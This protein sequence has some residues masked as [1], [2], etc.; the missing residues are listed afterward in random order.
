MTGSGELNFYGPNKAWSLGLGDSQIATT[1]A[2][3]SD[4]ELDLIQDGFSD[5]NF[6]FAWGGSSIHVG[7]R[8]WNDNVL[9]QT[10]NNPMYINGA[11][12]VGTNNLSIFGARQ[13]ALNADL[14]GTGNLRILSVDYIGDDAVAGAGGGV[15]FDDTELGHIADGWNNIAFDQSNILIID[16]DGYEFKDPTV[17]TT[18]NAGSLSVNDTMTV[19][20]GSNASFNFRGYSN[21]LAIANNIDINAEIDTSAAAPGAGQVTFGNAT[22]LNLGADIT[23]GG[24]D[25]TIADSV[26]TTT[27]DLATSNAEINLNADSGVISIGTGGVSA[28]DN[29][30]LRLNAEDFNINGDLTMRTLRF[31]ANNNVDFGLGDSEA[32]ATAHLSDAELDHIISTSYRTYFSANTLDVGA[33]S[34]N[35]NTQ[36]SGTINI[37]GTQTVNGG[38]SLTMVLGS[39]NSSINADLTGTGDLIFRVTGFG[40]LFEIGDG[41]VSAELNNA[42]LDRIVDGWNSIIFNSGNDGITFDTGGTYTFTD[43]VSFNARGGPGGGDIVI[44]SELQ[45]AAGSDAGYRFSSGG[46]AASHTADINA[47]IDLSAGDGTGDIVF[48]DLDAVSIGADITTAGGDI[49][50]ADDVTTTTLTT[51][52]ILDS[53]SGTISL[54]VGGLNAGANDVTFIA[55]DLM[56]NGA[57]T[58]TQNLRILPG[59]VSRSIGLGGGAGDLNINDAELALIN[60]GGQLIIGSANAGDI[61]LD[62]WDLSSTNYDVEIYGDEIDL[63]GITMGDGSFLAYAQ[64]TNSFE[65]L[66]VSDVISRTSAG[67][68]TLDLRANRNISL[69]TG[70][71]VISSTGSLNV[72]LNSDRDALLGGAVLVDG[73]SITTNDGY[74]VMGGGSGNIG[75]VDG[76]LGNG[77]GTGADDIFAGHSGSPGRGGIDISNISN[78][79]TGTGDIFVRGKSGNNLRD[80]ISIDSTAKSIT[81]TSGNISIIGQSSFTGRAV[82]ILNNNSI[83]TIDGD[84]DIHGEITGSSAPEAVYISMEDGDAIQTDNGNISITGIANGLGNKYGINLDNHPDFLINGSGTLTLSGQGSGTSAGIVS[85]NNPLVFGGIN[86][87]GNI[88]LRASDLDLSSG[89]DIQTTGDITILPWGSVTSIGLGGGAGDLNINDA[90]LAMINAGGKLI[91]GSNIV[92]TSDILSWDL[93]GTGYDIDLIAD[94]IQVDGLTLGAGQFTMLADNDI[95]IDSLI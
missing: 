19:Q 71:D 51:N 45:A 30:G 27:L 15:G 81:T 55:D 69:L 25:I 52:A 12:N 7:T 83:A 75:G 47:A 65:G 87:T 95:T 36:F 70:A 14:I 35:N 90:E 92:T 77:D 23:T 33:Y 72:I 89:G 40:N 34:W 68:A 67:T 39:T 78:I 13:T 9:F 60:A 82:K 91:I 32:G 22:N 11:Q 63:G 64:T 73:A 50:I 48:D 37:N 17:F 62:S 66:E 84:I 93:M 56:V 8:T 86:H 4:A 58:T 5:I 21:P 59:T 44:D 2:D 76:I 10:N 26:T 88:I 20:A 3:L 18:T 6:V 53:G 38:R 46:L 79:S 16:T 74:L 29:E 85:I 43:N 57:L 28:T 54:G 24:G 1:D 42:D 49:T 41:R 94:D 31:N 61:D 80:G